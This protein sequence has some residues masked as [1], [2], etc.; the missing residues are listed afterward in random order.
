MK[1]VTY[2]HGKYLDTSD[3]VEGYQS[4]LAALAAKH[5]S[6]MEEDEIY[7]W[8]LNH[9]I[10]YFEQ[11]VKSMINMHEIHVI[12]LDGNQIIDQFIVT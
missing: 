11:W 6:A 12:D 4:Y 7:E 8:W 9:F 2:Y 1:V 10:D 5:D 3:L